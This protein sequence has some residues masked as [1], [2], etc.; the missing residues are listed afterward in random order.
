MGY[1]R[2]SV[3]TQIAQLSVAMGKPGSSRWNYSR[4]EATEV[5]QLARRFRSRAAEA[6]DGIYRNLMLRTAS[7]LEE[8]AGTLSLRSGCGTWPS[9]TRG[10]EKR[11]L[12]GGLRFRI[13]ERPAATMKSPIR[14]VTGDR[15]RRSASG[16]KVD[17]C[18]EAMRPLPDMRPTVD[19]G[20]IDDRD[21][22]D[23]GEDIV[24]RRGRALADGFQHDRAPRR[25]AE[26]VDERIIRTKST[27]IAWVRGANAIATHSPPARC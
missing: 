13:V 27:Y 9:S 19:L 6:E 24:L 20:Q 14:A 17:S 11:G 23:A 25:V 18:R 5:A 21:V 26:A 15:H 16:I 22:G 2:L 10:E 8:L 7:E 3:F 4:L 12:S 1:H